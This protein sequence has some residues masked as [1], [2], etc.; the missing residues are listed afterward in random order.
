MAAKKTKRPA[1]KTPKV[2][3]KTTPKKAPKTR[4]PR[5]VVMDKFAPTFPAA[6]VEKAANW[7]K[8]VMGFKVG[9]IHKDPTGFAYYGILTRGGARLHLAQMLPGGPL[10]RSAAYLFLK[11]GVD[12]FAAQIY[13]RGGNII[14]AL[15]DHAY[16]MRECTVEDLD[17]NHIYVGQ[18]TE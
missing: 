5:P 1:G 9:T 13:A 3:K 2:A 11:T 14:S 15:K 10:G 7:Y 4:P 6:D 16:G 17:R 8:E 18:P 12:E